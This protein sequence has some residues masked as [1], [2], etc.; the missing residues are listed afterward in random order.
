MERQHV[1]VDVTA[2]HQ[3]VGAANK[4]RRHDAIGDDVDLPDRGHIKD[5]AL[6]H[7]VADNKYGAGDEESGED[8]RGARQKGNCLNI[9]VHRFDFTYCRFE[10]V[11]EMGRT[12]GSDR[13]LAVR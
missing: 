3:Y 13:T 7:H 6:D 8:T 10:I 12:T 4:R 5:V 11:V 9:T 1:H 2:G